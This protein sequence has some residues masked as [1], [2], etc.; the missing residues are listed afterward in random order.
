[1]GTGT[2]SDADCACQGDENKLSLFSDSKGRVMGELP[3][4]RLYDNVTTVHRA[5][6]KENN[7]A[8]QTEFI[9]HNHLL[10]FVHKSSQ[11]EGARHQWVHLTFSN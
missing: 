9:R 1:M 6:K 7:H 5:N 3:A 4:C 8:K 10:T 2:T 11:C